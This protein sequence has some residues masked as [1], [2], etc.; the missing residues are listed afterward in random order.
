MSS[1][2]FSIIVIFIVLSLVGCA[3]VPLLPVKLVPSRNLPSLTVSFS[4]ART[5]ETEVTSR[6]ESVLAHVGGVKG[7]NSKIL[8][9]ERPC[10]NRP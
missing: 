8:Q 2:S 4:S 6:L 5:V 3:L 1:R 10:V 7:I 9:W